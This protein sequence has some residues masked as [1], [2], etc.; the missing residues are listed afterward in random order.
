[1]ATPVELAASLLVGSRSLADIVAENSEV[2]T[3]LRKFNAVA[4]VPNPEAL[5]VAR[6]E[7]ANLRSRLAFDVVYGPTFADRQ[8]AQ[9]AVDACGVIQSQIIDVLTVGNPERGQILRSYNGLPPWFLKDKYGTQ[10]WIRAKNISDLGLHWTLWLWRKPQE[11]L[12]GCLLILFIKKLMDF[13]TKHLLSYS[14]LPPRLQGGDHGFADRLEID[15]YRIENIQNHALQ[16]I[17][18]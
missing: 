18:K 9:E 3:F 6:E 11:P 7:F 13:Q 2:A 8:K 10:N 1:M 5:G 4:A 15:V 16:N 12:H 14:F 17:Q